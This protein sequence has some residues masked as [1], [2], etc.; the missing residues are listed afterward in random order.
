MAAAR[1]AGAALPPRVPEGGERGLLENKNTQRAC[2]D[3]KGYRLSLA[4]MPR[5]FG[6]YYFIY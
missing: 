5:V 3:P 1:L 4:F 2:G 6:A